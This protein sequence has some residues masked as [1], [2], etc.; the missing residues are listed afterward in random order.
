MNTEKNLCGDIC[1]SCVCMECGSEFDNSSLYNREKD[2]QNLLGGYPEGET[3][4]DV[5]NLKKFNLDLATENE[6]LRNRIEELEGYQCVNCGWWLD[7]GCCKGCGNEWDDG[8][9]CDD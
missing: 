5:R 7:E 1:S 6:K 8:C 4:T 9:E 3:P 2:Y